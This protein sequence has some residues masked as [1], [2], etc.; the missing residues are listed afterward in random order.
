MTEIE[1]WKKVE[2]FVGV[3][4][5]NLCAVIHNSIFDDDLKTKMMNKVF[6]AMRIRRVSL[7]LYPILDIKSRKKFC[8]HQW[9]RL[10]SFGRCC[11]FDHNGD[12]NCHIHSSPG[13]LRERR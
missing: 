6:I 11:E 9:K 7:F 1:A 5:V 12:G 8:Q 10:E 2:V 13:V 4:D 3:H